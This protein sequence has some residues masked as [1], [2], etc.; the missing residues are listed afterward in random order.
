MHALGLWHKMNNLSINAI[1]LEG[2]QIFMSVHFQNSLQVRDF[3]ISH[4]SGKL[5]F[6]T[7]I[8]KS[9]LIEFCPKNKNKFECSFVYTHCI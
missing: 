7:F 8:A 5:N 4:L 6:L 1:S 3:G 2:K 9:L